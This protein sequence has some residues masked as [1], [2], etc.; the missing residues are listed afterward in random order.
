M[1]AFI[2]PGSTSLLRCSRLPLR[3]TRITTPPVVA[4]PSPPRRGLTMMAKRAKPPPS[5][6]PKGPADRNKREI[7]S[8][9]KESGFTPR[10]ATSDLEERFN[11][12]PSSADAPGPTLYERAAG[13][14]GADTL[15]AAEKQV[16]VALVVFAIVFVLC[17]VGISVEAYIKV[18][19]G[20]LVIG[21]GVDGVIVGFAE[22]VF[23][24]SLLG[25][26]AI[27]S[28][29]GVLKASQLGSGTGLYAEG[30]VPRGETPRGDRGD[31]GKGKAGKARKGGKKGKSGGF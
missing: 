31:V 16:G 9:M 8:I 15:A 28:A 24:P 7:S 19:G 27:S 20:S 30:E 4:A 11:R 12:P 18:T 26:L 17:G 21:E 2:P 23:T 14:V 1:E 5:T 6:A 22:K 3:R 25:F 10:T 29:Y 13:L